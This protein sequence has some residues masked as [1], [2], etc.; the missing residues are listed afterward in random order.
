MIKMHLNDM[1]VHAR[2]CAELQKKQL[3]GDLNS[4]NYRRFSVARLV[5]NADNAIETE[6]RWRAYE[7]CADLMNS[8][9][10]WT[11]NA[12]MADRLRG[13]I[14][15]M[16]DKVLRYNWPAEEVHERYRIGYTSAV[17]SLIEL[18]ES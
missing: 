7:R 13:A 3:I 8:P 9:E 2:E 18:L 14:A 10:I 15:K 5:F 12:T 6:A 16:S 4:L 1:R 11:E 17:A